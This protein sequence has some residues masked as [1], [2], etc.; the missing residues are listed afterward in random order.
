MRIRLRPASS[1]NGLLGLLRGEGDPAESGKP[2][3][4]HD[5]DD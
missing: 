1:A 2:G 3:R 4:F 5:A